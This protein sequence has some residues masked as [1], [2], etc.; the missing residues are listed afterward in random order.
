MAVCDCRNQNF[1][2]ILRDNDWDNYVSKK[3]VNRTSTSLSSCEGTRDS[4]WD[5]NAS[6]HGYDNHIFILLL[7]CVLPCF[8]YS[9]IS[10]TPWRWQPTC[11]FTILFF[12]HIQT[13]PSMTW[14]AC[15]IVCERFNVKVGPMAGLMAFKITSTVCVTSTKYSQ[16]VKRNFDTECW[17]RHWIEIEDVFLAKMQK[18]I[19]CIFLIS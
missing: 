12:Q 5:P 3:K 8:Q 4:V 1:T 19:S 17:H 14:D 6:H 7:N 15:R 18:N 16:T 11:V 10:T 2:K 9:T 13:L